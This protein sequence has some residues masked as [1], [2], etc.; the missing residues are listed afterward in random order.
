LIPYHLH[1]KGFY[2]EGS[3]DGAEQHL[4]KFHTGVS[5]SYTTEIEVNWFFRVFKIITTNSELNLCEVMIFGSE[6]VPNN[7]YGN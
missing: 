1:L 7:F 4:L 2:I 5:Y 3:I 6:T